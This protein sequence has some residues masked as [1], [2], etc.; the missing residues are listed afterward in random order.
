MTKGTS[1]EARFGV[2]SMQIPSS[3]SS[4]YTLRSG[5]MITELRTK[6]GWSCKLADNFGLDRGGTDELFRVTEQ[7]SDMMKAVF[8]ED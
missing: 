3:R 2:P 5:D 4:C 8:K 1:L 7:G 6:G